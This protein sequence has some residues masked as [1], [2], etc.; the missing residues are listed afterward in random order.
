MTRQTIN[1]QDVTGPSATSFPANC[2]DIT[3]T[4]A[5]VANKE[6]IQLD[7]PIIVLVKNDNVGAQTVTFSS[8]VCSHNRTNDIT[9]YSI[10]A[11]EVAAFEFKPHGWKQS[12]GYLHAEA[13]SADVKYAV[14][15]KG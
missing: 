10:G 11:S 12:T 4:A 6:Q 15:K 3:F 5:D 8:V 1:A 9:T 2:A 14:L 7:Y 13:T